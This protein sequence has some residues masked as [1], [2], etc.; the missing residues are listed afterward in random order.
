M[1]ERSAISVQP[2]AWLIYFQWVYIVK[3]GRERAIRGDSAS[4]EAGAK[5]RKPAKPARL[6]AE[7]C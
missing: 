5:Y 7:S 1:K 6:T 2:S 3:T 4:Y